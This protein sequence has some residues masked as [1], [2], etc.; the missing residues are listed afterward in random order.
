LTSLARS[1]RAF[2]IILGNKR[3][4]AMVGQGDLDRNAATAI[5]LQF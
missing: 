4:N 1:S 2:M 3:R 5:A